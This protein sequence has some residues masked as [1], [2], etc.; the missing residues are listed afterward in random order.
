VVSLLSFEVVVEAALACPEEDESDDARAVSVDAGARANGIGGTDYHAYAHTAVVH[1]GG[2][3]RDQGATALVPM[4]V[5]KLISTIP[6]MQKKAYLSI[7]VAHMRRPVVWLAWY[8]CWPN[9]VNVT[10]PIALMCLLLPGVP[11]PLP[12]PL[13]IPLPFPLAL[14][15]PL[16]IDISLALMIQFHRWPPTL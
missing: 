6:K 16:V 4:C 13:S 7:R 9:G 14:T 11:F 3:H 1:A 10:H 2:V 15:H 12:V 5:F 8:S